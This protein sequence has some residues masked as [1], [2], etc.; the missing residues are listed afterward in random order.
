MIVKVR[1]DI[2]P[3]LDSGDWVL[4][5][6]ARYLCGKTNIFALS[7]YSMIF[8]SSNTHQRKK[9]KKNKKKKKTKEKGKRKKE[10][11]RKRKRKKFVRNDLPQELKGNKWIGKSA[12]PASFPDRLWAEPIHWEGW[13][14]GGRTSSRWDWRYVL[15]RQVLKYQKSL[16]DIKIRYGTTTVS[17]KG[18]HL[19]RPLLVQPPPCP[20]TSSSNAELYSALR[21]NPSSFSVLTGGMK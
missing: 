16:V 13:L 11:E 21:C 2:E 17:P 5:T 20:S 18:S 6:G 19:I 1:F 10:K 7:L 15:E 9:I 4:E 8:C 14:R 3:P 12:Q